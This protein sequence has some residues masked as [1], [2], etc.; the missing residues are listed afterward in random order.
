[1]SKL[2]GELPDSFLFAEDIRIA[3]VKLMLARDPSHVV[4]HARRLVSRRP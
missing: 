2:F 4:A 3:T 1:M